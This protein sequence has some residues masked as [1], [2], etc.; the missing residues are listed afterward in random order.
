MKSLFISCSFLF[1]ALGGFAQKQTEQYLKNTIYYLASDKLGGRNTGSPG[2]KLASDYIVDQYKQIGILPMGD[3]GRYL[4]TFSFPFGKSRD[5]EGNKH[6]NRLGIMVV[7]IETYI[8]LNY[9]VD[10]FPLVNSGNGNVDSTTINTIDV[11]YG[12]VSKEKNYDDYSGKNVSGKIALIQIST[13]D[14]DNPH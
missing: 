4:Q 10:Y 6:I 14:G 3:S 11:G 2:E 5:D 13:P 8:P 9:G 12:I 7:G 1:I